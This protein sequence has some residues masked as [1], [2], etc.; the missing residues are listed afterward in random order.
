MNLIDFEHVIEP[1]NDIYQQIINNELLNFN[2][3]NSSTEII[4]PTSGS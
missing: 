1:L 4:H 2:D 3:N